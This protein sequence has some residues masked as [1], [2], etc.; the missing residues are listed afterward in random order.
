M[1]CELFIIISYN[2]VCCKIKFQVLRY[3]VTFS[4]YSY[5]QTWCMIWLWN[6]VIAFLW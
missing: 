2:I 1:F 3:Y 4:I 5:L 6:C